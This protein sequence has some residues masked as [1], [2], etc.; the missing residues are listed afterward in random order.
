MGSGGVKLHAVDLEDSNSLLQV[1]EQLTCS[2][3]GGDLTMAQS[4]LDTLVG[5]ET[6]ELMV[7]TDGSG[8]ANFEQLRFA[9]EKEL[10]V[11]GS[12][13][14]NVANEYT[15]CTLREDGLYDVMVSLKNYSEQSVSLDVSLFGEEGMLGLASKTLAA[16]ERSFACSKVWNVRA[17]PLHQKLVPFLL[18][19][20]KK[21][22]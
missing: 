16:S 21:I 15:V 12:A 3:G 5:E 17:E 19:I 20:K 22:V 6:A 13:V 14:S 18:Q 9:G 11:C 7:Y 1:L 10:Y 8:A 4:L 2:D